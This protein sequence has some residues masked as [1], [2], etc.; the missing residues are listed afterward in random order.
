LTAILAYGVKWAMKNN[1]PG[2]IEPAV[3]S[4]YVTHVASRFCADI[5]TYEVWNEPDVTV[6][7][8]PKPDAAQYVR[9]L[10]A[11]YKAVKAAC[12]DAQVI[13]GGLGSNS[14]YTKG[15]WWFLDE[16]AAARPDLC[17]I[18]DILGLHPYTADSLPPE[19]DRVTSKGWEVRGQVEMTR[20]AREKLAKMGCP[21]KPLWF[22]EIGWASYKISEEQQ[23]RNLVRSALLALRDGVDAWFWYTAFDMAPDCSPT[24]PAECLYG[25]FGWPGAAEPR[26]FKPAFKAL[27]DLIMMLGSMR[28]S[29][30][31]S[32]ELGL[33]NDVYALEFAGADG[34]MVLALWDGRDWPDKDTKFELKLPVPPGKAN[35][36]MLSID[37][38][39]LP[40]PSRDSSGNITLTL[41]PSVVYLRMQGRGHPTPVF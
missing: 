11:A 5:K 8:K 13:S 9:L 40:A 4:D 36:E 15:A 25:L 22:T 14:D 30:D 32:T 35:V 29:R 16:M 19:Y 37:G 7:W 41:T 27:K 20:L 3:F 10:E 26:R 21:E 23:G 24:A 6:F 17:S 38:T 1:E 12:P 2:T 28:F 31:R 18:F 34:S 33:P 39:M